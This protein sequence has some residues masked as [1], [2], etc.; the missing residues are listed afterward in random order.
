MRKHNYDSRLSV[1]NC[2]LWS[3]VS[4][5]TAVKTGVSNIVCAGYIR[6]VTRKRLNQALVQFHSGTLLVSARLYINGRVIPRDHRCL[7]CLICINYLALTAV[8]WNTAPRALLLAVT[9]CFATSS[10]R[11]NGRIQ[12]FLLIQ[13]KSKRVFRCGARGVVFHNTTLAAVAKKG[14]QAGPDYRHNQQLIAT[15]IWV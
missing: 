11:P 8:S 12:R 9:R 5:V 1:V 7:L 15:T 14:R 2:S 13:L 6:W 10:V 3:V 4:V